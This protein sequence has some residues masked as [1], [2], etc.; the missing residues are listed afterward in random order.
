MAHQPTEAQPMGKWGEQRVVDARTTEACCGLYLK[1]KE[2]TLKHLK[3]HEGTI[4][5][6]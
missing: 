5:F 3:Q 1:N 2:E 4:T 6:T